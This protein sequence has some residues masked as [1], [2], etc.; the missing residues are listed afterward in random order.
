MTVEIISWSIS[1][2]V[3]YRAGIELATPGSAVRLASVATHV[4]DC[5]MLPGKVK[6]LW[7]WLHLILIY[8]V[9]KILFNFYRV[10]RTVHFWQKLWVQWTFNNSNV[11]SGLFDNSYAYSELFTTV[12]RTVH[13]WQKVCVQFT[14]YN[15]YVYSSLFTTVMRTVHF[16]GQI[17]CK[18]TCT[19]Y[20]YYG[21]RF[22][23]YL[24]KSNIFL[25]D[26]SREGKNGV[27]L[28]VFV[29]RLQVST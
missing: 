17:W 26:F 27:T 11:Y 16:L 7:S 9:F 6:I 14:F 3:W 20:S 4:T 29:T 22:V 24:D 10:M 8:T 21:N 12:M 19:N 23:F 13:F 1:T 15:S 25:L 5:A 2:K 28:S 18:I